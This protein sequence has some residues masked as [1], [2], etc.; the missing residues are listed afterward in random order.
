MH[1][2]LIATSACGTDPAGCRNHGATE[3]AVFSGGA[4]PSTLRLVKHEDVRTRLTA[5]GGGA[6]GRGFLEI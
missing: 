4:D 6:F 5:D 2:H 3:V 1:G